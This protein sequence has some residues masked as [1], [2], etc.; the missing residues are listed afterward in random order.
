MDEGKKSEKHKYQ[1]KL[2][3]IENMKDSIRKTLQEEING[4]DNKNDVDQSKKINYLNQVFRLPWDSTVEPFWDIKH[5]ANVLEGSHYGQTEV[6][7]RI[8]EFI[9]K[10]K[11]V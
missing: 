8:L 6:K 11:R 3:A 1:E 4:L 7:E 10:N 2:D 9:A 5:S